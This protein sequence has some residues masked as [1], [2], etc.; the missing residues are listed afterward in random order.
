MSGLCA[1]PHRDYLRNQFLEQALEVSAD[2]QG[3]SAN[4]TLLPPF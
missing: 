2:D 4:G 1:F 3:A